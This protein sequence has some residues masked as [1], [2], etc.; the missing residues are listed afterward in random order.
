MKNVIRNIAIQ[1]SGG[2]VQEEKLHGIAACQ[3][4][5]VLSENFHSMYSPRG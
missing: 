2:S 1:I 3:T 4:E 5:D